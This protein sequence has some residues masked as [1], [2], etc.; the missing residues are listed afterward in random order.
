MK[1]SERKPKCTAANH[2][3]GH[4]GHFATASALS[5]VGAG[6]KSDCSNENDREDRVT[7]ARSVRQDRLLLT[8][9]IY[10]RERS[11]RG[12]GPTPRKQTACLDELS[13][14]QLS[15]YGERLRGHQLKYLTLHSLKTHSAQAAPC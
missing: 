8:D 10:T 2:T 7:P 13:Y 15:A 14:S 4:D 11:V 5:A 3:P 6:V 1:Q 9:Y 12:V